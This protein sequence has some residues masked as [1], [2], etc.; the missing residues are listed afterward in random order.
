MA[1]VLTN[2]NI[3]GRSGVTV[4]SF[5]N[6]VWQQRS[7]VLKLAIFWF[8]LPVLLYFATRG[9]F[10]SK[11]A[12][13]AGNYVLAQN[14]DGM[15]RGRLY[16]S[17][18]WMLAGFAMFLHRKRIAAV[19][20]RNRVLLCLPCLAILSTVW[21]DVPGETLRRGILIL[22][23][24]IFALYLSDRFT[25]EQHLQ[26]FYYLGA[27]AAAL[28]LLCVVALPAYGISPDG[29]WKGIFGHKNDLGV[30]MVFFASAAL[31]LPRQYGAAKILRI[32]VLLAALILVAF[33]Q[34]RSGW[35]VTIA[36]AGFFFGSTVLRRLGR[37]ARSG[38]L[39]VFVVLVA[40]VVMVLL[41]NYAAILS[42]I[43]K[44]A[45]L[46]DRTEIWSAVLISIFKQPLLGYGYGAFWRGLLGP[47]ADVIIRIN[48]G[49][50]HAHNGFLNLWLELGAVGLSFV[51][52]MF[53]T[54]ARQAL[55]IRRWSDSV[56]WYMGLIFLVLVSNFDESFLFNNN[57][58][59]WMLFVLACAQLTWIYRAQRLQTILEALRQASE[60]LAGLTPALG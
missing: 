56:R 40:C 39:A 27:C 18:A 29:S 41:E 8:L 60:T 36:Y 48:F 30:F 26:I 1:G 14:D 54:A 23:S 2:E 5:G 21:S 35:L 44:D 50:A 25:P 4:N 53:V 3:E 7:S 20:A 51:V 43:G 31:Y 11:P 49:I 37:R 15:A 58:L 19:V 38:L 24:T 46:S 45:T 57:D 13:I 17:A 47:S 33:S 34:S 16:V 32:F 42:L 22:L 9:N 10:L 52:Y 59:I 12:A 6:L 28:S 55:R